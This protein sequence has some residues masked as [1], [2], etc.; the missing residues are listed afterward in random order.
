MPHA[1]SSVLLSSGTTAGSHPR[2]AACHTVSET[3][4]GPTARTRDCSCPPFYSSRTAFWNTTLY[5]AIACFEASIPICLSCRLGFGTR[6]LGP[7]HCLVVAACCIYSLPFRYY[8]TGSLLFQTWQCCL[9]SSFYYSLIRR[10]PRSFLTFSF[11]ICD[12]G[13]RTW[14]LVAS[15]SFDLIG[16]VA[17]TPSLVLASFAISPV[18]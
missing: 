13:Q 11:E 3:A 7:C 16:W 8:I 14:A 17:S 9:A 1:G 4:P 5:F 12:P 10:D 15:V 18:F 6:C 2:R